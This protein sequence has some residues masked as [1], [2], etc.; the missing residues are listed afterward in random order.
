MVVLKSG[1]GCKLLRSSMSVVVS[2]EETR[3]VI[4]AKKM[5]EF[6]D[7][8]EAI[9]RFSEL[10]PVTNGWLMIQCCGRAI[11]FCKACNM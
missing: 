4:V 6:V 11:F 9:D 7:I 3:S 5:V 1:G 10:V 8:A 2:V